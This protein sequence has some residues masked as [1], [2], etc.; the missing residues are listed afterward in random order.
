MKDQRRIAENQ[1]EKNCVAAVN[2]TCISFLSI[3]WIVSIPL[4]RS[5]ATKYAEPFV[6]PKIC[7][8]RLHYLYVCA[9][10]ALV[11]FCVWVFNTLFTRLFF[12]YFC[13]LIWLVRWCA[14]WYQSEAER[15]W[16]KRKHFVS[17]SAQIRQNSRQTQTWYYHCFRTF[18]TP[19]HNSSFWGQTVRVFQDIYSHRGQK[20][21]FFSFI[22][23]TLCGYTIE[24][25]SFDHMHNEP[26]TILKFSR[27]LGIWT[28]KI[29]HKIVINW[30]WK[31]TVTLA[32]TITSNKWMN[33]QTK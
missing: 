8:K 14:I 2:S 20:F 31:R 3:I 6:S 17:S 23:C 15:D 25:F 16:I 12:V 10:C 11:C 27:F 32:A 18:V 7:N 13:V 24:S 19:T 9:V 5:F 4:K 26:E 29:E 22:S 30:N 28:V 1:Q 33:K 21:M